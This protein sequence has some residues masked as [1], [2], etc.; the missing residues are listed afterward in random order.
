MSYIHAPNQNRAEVKG[1]KGMFLIV[2]LIS[3]PAEYISAF[4][5]VFPNSLLSG[6]GISFVLPKDLR[7]Y[8]ITTDTRKEE[9][10]EEGALEILIL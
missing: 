4:C 1:R 8:K 9:E 3:E 5:R 7:I 10:E 6:T 2:S